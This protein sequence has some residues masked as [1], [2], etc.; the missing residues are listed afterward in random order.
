MK[1]AADMGTGTKI[2]TPCFIKTGLD[3]RKLEGGWGLL[4]TQTASRW[5]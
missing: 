1:Y 5:H 3:I 2:Y 4:D